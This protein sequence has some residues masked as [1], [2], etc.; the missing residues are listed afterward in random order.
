[1][2]IWTSLAGR[3]AALLGAL[4]LLGSGPAAFL[5]DRFAAASRIALAPGLGFCLGTCVTTTLLWF[6]PVNSTYWILAPLA[7][8]SVAVAAVR[9]ARSHRG[10]RWATRLPLRDVEALVLVAVAVTGPVNATLHSHHTVGP[11][12][13][14]Y[15]DGDN[16]ISTQDAARTVSLRT[17]A[18]NWNEHVRTGKP[19]GDYN[20]LTWSF[21][22]Q[23]GSNLDATPLDSSVNALLGLGATDTFA[24]FLTVLLLMGALGAFAAVRYFTGSGTVV[25]AL[26]GALFGGALFLELWFD[27]FQAAIVANGLL[28]PAAVLFDQA[29]LIRRR[30]A[31]V[32]LGLLLATYLTV[33]PLYVPIVTLAGLLVM[34]WHAIRLR[35]A[36]RPLKPLRRPVALS[37]VA[38][39]VMALAFDPVAVAR[40]IHYYK[41]ILHHQIPLPRVGW[42]LPIYEIPGWVGQTR[43]FWAL[44]GLW[45]GGLKQM[46]LGLVLPFVFLGFIV[47]GLR[48]YPRAL[49]LVVIAAVAS[50]FAEYAYLS[51]QNCTYCAE[52]DL[53]TLGPVVAILIPIG[54]AALL[55]MPSRWAKVAGVAGTA[56]VVAAVGQRVRIELIRFSDQSYFLD[57]GTRRVVES[58]PRGTGRVEVEGFGASVFAQA[59]QPIVYHDVNW[60]SGGRASIIAGS[61][62]S[63]AIQ[64]LD[65]G[66]IHLPPAPPSFDP[67][68]RYVLTRLAGVAT[69]RQVIAREGSV[70]L[71]RRVKPLDVTPYA[72]L[73]VPYTSLDPGV[74]WVQTQYPLQMYVVGY[75]GE[76]PAWARLTFQA[77][78]P[79]S[80]PRQAGVRSALAGHTLTVCVRAAGREPV[81]DVNLALHANLV[82]GPPPPDLFPPPMPAEGVVLTGMRAVTGDCSV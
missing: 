20:Q 22:S 39:A 66:A 37:I 26:A 75:D 56:L 19:W 29:L 62:L 67:R 8:A 10:E 28:A 72:G 47:F 58:I 5:S 76:R 48:R 44:T 82:P 53:L 64:Y 4:L 31:L 70:A 33:Y 45:E 80:V 81:R 43:E 24:P 18:A 77:S 59:E 17:A 57:S 78:V 12:L 36:E 41:L 68:Y 61:D 14:Y 1:M 42:T 11:A 55:S 65:L 51:Q 13:F 73:A 16:Y 35:R 63:N 71:E 40:D 54:L 3:E 27:S 6:A 15:T 34:T 50:V 46:L 52:R 30:S 23:L 7:V 2:H 32:L 74:A 49:T 69:D 25:A 21:I 60:N 9:T 38:V 79:V